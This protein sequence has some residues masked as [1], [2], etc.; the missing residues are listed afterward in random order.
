VNKLIADIEQWGLDKGILP[1]P[2]KIAQYFKTC[3]EVAELDD[4][5]LTDNRE[6]AIDAIGDIVVTLIMQTHAW[7]VTLEQCVQQAYGTI[8]K[9]TGKMVNGQ[10]VKD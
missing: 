9:R 6:E 8:S 10:F 2:N 4:A 1:N 3:E 5:I 7:D